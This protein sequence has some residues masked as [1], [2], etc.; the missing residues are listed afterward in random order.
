VRFLAD[1]GVGQ[2]VV[3]KL[4]AGG[5]G[6]SNDPHPAVADRHLTGP[7]RFALR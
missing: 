6:R 4:R 3:E 5:G 2:S 7:G 1:M